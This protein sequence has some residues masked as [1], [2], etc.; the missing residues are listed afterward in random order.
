MRGA[1]VARHRRARF[2][3]GVAVMVARRVPARCRGRTGLTTVALSGG[4]WQ[5][6][7]AAGPDQCAC[8][9]AGALEVLVH[10]SRCPPTTAGS[11]SGRPPWRPR[12]WSGRDE[13]RRRCVS[14][15][16]G[17]ITEICERTACCAW[18]WSTSAASARE[19]CLAYVPEAADAA[20]TCSCTW[21]S[22]S[23][24]STRR[25]RSATLD[26]AAP[27]AGRGIEDRAG[28]DGSAVKHLDEYRD[29]RSRRG[30]CSPRS[31][32]EATAPVGAHGG[33]RRADALASCAA[34]STSCCPTRSTLVHGPGCPVCVTPLE[35]ID[36]ALAIAAPAR[37]DLRS[38]SATCCACRAPDGDLFAVRA[39]RAATC[40]SSTRRST[41][42]SSRA[43][44]PTARWSS[45]PSAS[46]RPRRPTR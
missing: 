41:R 16:P 26:G 17:Q 10:R 3:R 21:A 18:A 28:G 4:V 27:G 44:T 25:R 37:G 14:A 8:C 24:S 23:A 32:R 40:A 6:L 22:R 33:L 19:V 46:R 35:I 29:G 34:A 39:A 43:R 38:A 7:P 45:S 5:N 30:A 36:R 31:D 13:E 11:R 1:P 42:V 15:F 9:E 2:H 20:T 12:E